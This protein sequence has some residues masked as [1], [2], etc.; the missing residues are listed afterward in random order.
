M[1]LEPKTPLSALL[2]DL[3]ARIIVGSRSPDEAFVLNSIGQGV[4]F[5]QVKCIN[6]PTFTCMGGA[7]IAERWTGI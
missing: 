4:T 5:Q 2:S 3:R 1:I 7:L 6:L